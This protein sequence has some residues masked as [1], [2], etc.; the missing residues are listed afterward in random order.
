MKSKYNRK[1]DE[2]TNIT[3]IQNNKIDELSNKITELN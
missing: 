1:I 2:L 3:Q